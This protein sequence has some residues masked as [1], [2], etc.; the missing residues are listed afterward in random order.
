[1]MPSFA[2]GGTLRLAETQV[3]DIRFRV[4]IDPQL[5]GGE[6]DESGN[7]LQDSGNIFGLPL[8]YLGHTFPLFLGFFVKKAVMMKPSSEPISL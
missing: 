1:M 6:V 8:G 3:Q 7:C 4:V 5:L 2:V